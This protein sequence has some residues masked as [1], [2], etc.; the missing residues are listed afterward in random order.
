MSNQFKERLRTYSDLALESITK[1]NIKWRFPGANYCYKIKDRPWSIRW[2]N[3]DP[4]ENTMEL[5]VLLRLNSNYI[6]EITVHLVG[7][8]FVG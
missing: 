6:E 3:Y 8:A 1:N 2:Y 5:V 4:K 7:N